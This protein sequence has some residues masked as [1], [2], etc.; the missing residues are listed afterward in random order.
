MRACR[1]HQGD[2]ELSFHL[3]R[4]LVSGIFEVG[5]TLRSCTRNGKISVTGQS[6]LGSSLRFYLLGRLNEVR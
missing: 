6:L 5:R 4:L 1:C 3:L 2:R